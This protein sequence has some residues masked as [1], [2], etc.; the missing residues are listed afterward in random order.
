MVSDTETPPGTKVPVTVKVIPL[1]LPA[2]VILIAL[3]QPSDDVYTP[4]DTNAPLRVA[5]VALARV[6]DKAILFAVGDSRVYTLS[7][8][9][10]ILIL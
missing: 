10:G 4:L 2:D 9:F 8:T 1:S 5:L 6:W 7:F 3:E